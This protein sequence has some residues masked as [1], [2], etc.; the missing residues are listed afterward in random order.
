MNSGLEHSWFKM[1]IER[2]VT[3]DKANW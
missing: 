3:T 2:D 1:M